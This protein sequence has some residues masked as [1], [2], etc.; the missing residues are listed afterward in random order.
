MHKAAAGA[1][2]RDANGQWT[3]TG[4]QQAAS[5]VRKE[6]YKS[7]LMAVATA[8]T[9]GLPLQGL[10]AGLAATGIDAG[11]SKLADKITS[12]SDADAA[13]A[14]AGKAVSTTPHTPIRAKIAK[15][16]NAA[17]K[18]AAK[19]LPELAAK[20]GTTQVLSHGI[21]AGLMAMNVDPGTSAAISHIAAAGLEP[22]VRQGAN[23]LIQRFKQK[24]TRNVSA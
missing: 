16:F 12:P 19:N 20:V 22:G 4:G 9:G 24:R 5:Q 23:Y 3:S 6:I 1:Q 2:P 21:N 8:A 10:A 7:G 17:V 11:V 14:K 15:A 18:T 13:R